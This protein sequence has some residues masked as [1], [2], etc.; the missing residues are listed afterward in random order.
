[1]NLIFKIKYWLEERRERKKKKK[2]LSA[3]WKIYST[4]SMSFSECMNTAISY[5]GLEPGDYIGD[6][7][8]YGNLMFMVH[9]FEMSSK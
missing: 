5:H 9:K 3:F 8:L 7:D 6:D 1:M 4:T 2:I